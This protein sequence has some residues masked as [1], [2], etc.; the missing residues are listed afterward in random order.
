MSEIHCEPI[1]LY[2]EKEEGTVLKP[3]CWFGLQQE[4]SS[5][6]L[7]DGEIWREKESRCTNFADTVP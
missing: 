7:V 1:D 3:K 6:V 2:F 4:S 5:S